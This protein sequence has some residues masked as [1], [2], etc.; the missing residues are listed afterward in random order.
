MERWKYV[1]VPL[2]SA[3]D[4]NPLVW[5][6]RL[7]QARGHEVCMVVQ[8][9]MAEYSMRAGIRT[10]PAGSAA[11]QEM[12]VRNPD[13]WH[14]MK[15]FRLLARHFPGWAE[16]MVPVI[17]SEVLPGRTV[18]VA[19]GIAFGAKI[20]AELD[21]VPLVTVALQPSILMSAHDC[22]VLMAG[23]EPFKRRPLWL[24]RFV[25]WLGLRE[26]DRRLA[27]P[28]NRVRAR[29]GLTRPARNIMTQW[30][31]ST[32]L[33]LALFPKWFAAPQPDWPRNTVSTRF[34]MYDESGA[35]PC[36]LELEN[37]L[38]AGPPPVLLTPGSAN[39]HA[40]EFFNAG[41]VACGRIGQRALFIT[42]HRE[43]LPR[44]LPAGAGHFEFAPFGQVFPRCL[45]VVHHGGIGTCAQGMGAGVPQLI[46][47]MAHDQPD[48]GW[49][50][51]QLGAGD[52]L[53]P[54]AFTADAVTRALEHLINSDTVRR[55]CEE[56][57][58]KMGQQIRPEAVAG[59]LEQRI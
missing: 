27:G 40:T 22:P 1:F 42:P 6:A 47:A 10:L 45:A 49:R 19:G 18:L 28:I 13:L 26:T 37:W 9:G 43:H 16:E 54:K 52:Y 30:S 25:L 2:G 29:L 58:Q 23:M 12:V 36:S 51:K 24:R 17:R 53:S 35:R 55:A 31:V 21:R 7:M 4:V 41:A 59:I 14:P 11:Q 46:M 8:A 34:P 39:L 33:V 5:L 57:K 20:V 48:N 38:K 3:G 32:D 44:P 56:T 15:A 50:I